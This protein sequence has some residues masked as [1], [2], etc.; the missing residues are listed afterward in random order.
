MVFKKGTHIVATRM[1]YS[2]HG[3]YIGNN[4]VV[5]Y[6]GFNE[7]AKKGKIIKTS[8]NQFVLNGKLRKY[9]A[10]EFLR[11]NQYSDEEI[12]QR[13]LSRLGEDEYNVVFNNCEHFANW[14]T[15]DD[16]F[17]SQT[18]GMAELNIRMGNV[19]GT[20]ISLFDVINNFKKKK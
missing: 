19:M 15:H 8:L 14:C 16:D 1:G 7:F 18:A 10:T 13:A 2:H 9:E 5:H 3:I 17:S 11:G 4:N 12:V 20:G 6:S